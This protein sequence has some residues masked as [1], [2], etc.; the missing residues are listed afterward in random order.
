MRRV[1]WRVRRGEYD[2]DEDAAE[3]TN[4]KP[5]LT[6]QP[7]PFSHYSSSSFALPSYSP[8][9]NSSHYRDFV[10]PGLLKSGLTFAFSWLSKQARKYLRGFAAELACLTHYRGGLQLPRTERP[11][12]DQNSYPPP[13]Q[14]TQF[15]TA[16][17]ILSTIAQPEKRPHFCQHALHMGC[18]ALSFSRLCSG[19]NRY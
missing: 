13:K 14:N 7:D 3:D 2:I 15:V 18:I 8:P 5:S 9:S 4:A 1:R 12:P 19:Q 11:R 16:G 10:D 6:L 17:S